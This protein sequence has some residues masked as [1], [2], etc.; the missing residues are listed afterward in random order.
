MMLEEHSAHHKVLTSHPPVPPDFTGIH[1][2]VA[3]VWINNTVHLLTVTVVAISKEIVCRDWEET[4]WGRV[5]A[6]KKEEQGDLCCCCELP[7]ELKSRLCLKDRIWGNRKQ[8]VTMCEDSSEENGRENV[9]RINTAW[10][11]HSGS[12]HNHHTGPQCR[13]A[14]QKKNTC[15]WV[16]FFYPELSL[17][18]LYGQITWN[19][20]MC[21]AILA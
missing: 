3:E 12:T 20:I 11:A 17:E 14:H 21:C 4:Q 5:G 16:C 19:F 10:I 15:S 8:P 9:L 18:R 2:K 1:W 13:K 7:D 6:L